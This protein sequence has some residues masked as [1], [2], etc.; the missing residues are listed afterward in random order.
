MTRTIATL[1]AAVF[2]CSLGL[3]AQNADVKTPIAS[4]APQ[5][6]PGADYRLGAGDLIE[7]RVFGVSDF[8][9]SLRVSAAGTIK[10][11]LIEP[12]VAAGLTSTELERTLTRM[13]DGDVIK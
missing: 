11:P 1:I 13:L 5:A 12:V 3:S 9:H 6:N 4:P 7:I 10:L 2:G 8:D